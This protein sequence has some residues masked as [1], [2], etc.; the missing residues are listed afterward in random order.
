MKSEELEVDDVKLGSPPSR[1]AWIEIAARAKIA[2]IFESPP[3]RAA[4]IEIKLKD[5]PDVADTSPPS[6]AAWIE[7]VYNIKRN[8]IF[9]S[10]PSRAAWIEISL[11]NCYSEFATVAAFTG[12]V[13]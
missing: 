7:I 13:D 6:R 10:P 3:S 11:C 12:G 1:A 8:Q 5:S 4:W 2:Q 9:Q